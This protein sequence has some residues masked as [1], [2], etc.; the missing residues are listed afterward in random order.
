MS[1][2]DPVR[3][4]VAAVRE[5][6]PLQRA[7]ARMALVLIVA[8][9]ATAAVAASDEAAHGSGGFSSALIGFVGSL[10]G[11]GFA[12]AAAWGATRMEVRRQREDN[13][14][15]R[16][17]IASLQQDVAQVRADVGYL[18]GAI[19]HENGAR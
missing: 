12:F 1:P 10:L 16:A 2:L 7:A 17:S 19:R 13:L 14:E 6:W 15:L 4:S 18:H 3:E 11:A 9:M 8:M 5:S